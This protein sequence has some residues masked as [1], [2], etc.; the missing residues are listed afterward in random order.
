VALSEALQDQLAKQGDRVKCSVVCPGFVASE[1]FDNFEAL[2]PDGVPS[3]E[4]TPEG[5]QIIE[6]EKKLLATGKTPREAGEIVLQAIRDERFYVLTHPDWANMVE[7]RMRA[8]L[9][10]TDPARPIPPLGGAL[11]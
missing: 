9:D 10:G 4:R 1:V 6:V 8:I 2:K 11:G 5:K 3:P 7:G